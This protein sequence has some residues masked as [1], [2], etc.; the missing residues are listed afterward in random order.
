VPFTRDD[1]GVE[2]YRLRAVEAGRRPPMR[3][4]GE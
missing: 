1:I 3:L 4:A 2:E